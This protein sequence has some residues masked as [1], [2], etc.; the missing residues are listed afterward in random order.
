MEAMK[1]AAGYVRVSTTAQAKE[2]ESLQTQKDSIALFCE[3]HGLEL[4][5]LITDEG[6]WGKSR[7]G[8][9]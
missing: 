5:E 9:V 6:V 1:K 4:V 3:S 7:N 8:P 2:G